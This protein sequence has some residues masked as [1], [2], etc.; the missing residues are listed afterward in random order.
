[1]SDHADGRKKRKKEVRPVS[2][3][4]NEIGSEVTLDIS[5]CK[6][7]QLL[8]LWL[9]CYKPV[10]SKLLNIRFVAGVLRDHT[11]LTIKSLQCR[12]NIMLKHSLVEFWENLSYCFTFKEPT[13][14]S[15]G[16]K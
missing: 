15:L 6:L 12:K 8:T 10:P 14:I 11:V 7:A 5:S 2:E 16:Q 1:M 3:V 13:R 9:D 4:V